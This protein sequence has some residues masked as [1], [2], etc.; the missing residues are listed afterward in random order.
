MK[1]LGNFPD[2]FLGEIAGQPDALRRAASGLLAQAEA[3]RSAR[4]SV[5]RARS[6]V[7]TGM[8]G[9]YHA[10]YAPVTRLAA[11]GVRAQMIDCA[12]LLHFRLAQVGRDALVIA[13][14]QSGES[15]ELVRL[16]EVLRRRPDRPGLVSVTNGV[17]N[18]LAERADL[19]LDTTAGIEVGP[20]TLTFAAALTVLCELAGDDG[21]ALFAAAALER[22]LRRPQGTAEGLVEWLG[23]R[24]TV[25][26]LGRGC[27]RAAAEMGALTLK[28][29]AR[30]PAESMQSAQF[31]HGPLE[32]AGPD[33]AAIVV[34]TEERTRHLD[35]ALAAELAA[36]G[37]AVLAVTQDGDE[38]VGVR[39]FAI[40]PLCPAIAPAVAILPVQLLAWRLAVLR[41]RTPDELALAAKV[42][43][44]E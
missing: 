42:T 29:A 35:L 1:S 8:G 13:V 2:R 18:S 12:E 37:S 44:R 11:Q 36:A 22:L 17:A 16:A 3:A 30:L 20:S 41:G 43:V 34:A 15:A 24:Q 5:A 23:D 28:E 19:A 21:Q 38:P 40:G 6:V 27:A 10:C 31:R 39:P 14:S 32:L 25:T 9:S 7:F 4:L 33:L 26:V